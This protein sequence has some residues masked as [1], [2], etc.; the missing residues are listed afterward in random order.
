M[1]IS[2][3]AALVSLSENLPNWRLPNALELREYNL[4]EDGVSW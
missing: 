3:S 4:S 2:I 1:S